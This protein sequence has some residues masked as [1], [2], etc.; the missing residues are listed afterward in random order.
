ML[1]CLKLN[2]FTTQFQIP[3][4]NYSNGWLTFY[5]ALIVIA[6]QTAFVSDVGESIGCC[7]GI[8]DKIT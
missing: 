1:K 7:L 3:P 2:H 8:P 4:V 5:G 6:I